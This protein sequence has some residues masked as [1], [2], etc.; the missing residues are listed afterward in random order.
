MQGFPRGL[1]LVGLNFLG[2]FGILGDHLRQPGQL[3]ASWVVQDQR[4]GNSRGHHHPGLALTILFNCLTSPLECKVL[5]G[6][7]YNIVTI[8]HSEVSVVLGT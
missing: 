5:R 1:L 2:C 6:E 8:E 7:H 4:C 3:G